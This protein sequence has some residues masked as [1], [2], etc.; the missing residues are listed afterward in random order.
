VALA[1][2]VGV[3]ALPR[4]WAT[5][6]WGLLG[7]AL[8]VGSSIVAIL[9]LQNQM[10]TGDWRVSP[11]V[12]Y[13]REYLPSDFPGFG[14]D[15]SQ[16]VAPLPLDLERSRQE[17]FE[18]RRQHTL[19]ALPET[20]FHRWARSLTIVVFGWRIGLLTLILLGLFVMPAA[21][22]VAFTMSVGLLIAYA[23]H[24]HWPQWSQYYLEA[25]PAYA[26]AL[27]AGIWGLASWIIQGWS[28]IRQRVLWD[29][30]VADSRIA[31]ATAL[32]A[33][34][35]AIP[36]GLRVPTTIS[37]YQAEVTYQR[38]FGEALRFVNAES[39]KAIVFVEYGPN[40]NAHFSL[41]RNVPNLADAETWIVYE[42][43]HDD[44]RL[45]RLAPDRRAYIY[46]ADEARLTRLPP[47]AELERIVMAR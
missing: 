43:G 7:V 41:I 8:L 42:R 28:T 10:T 14:F 1:L 19:S 27:A 6:A 46:H 15:S 45:M 16:P 13:S 5:R 12:K 20:L 40:H 24:S 21:G 29:A 25:A 3:A 34:A 9:P 22:I 32:T 17:L 39:D 37:R 35:L 44:L 30:G 2:P 38:R 4:I 47:L 31:V 26:F 36:S 11:L 18:A 33:V 23:S